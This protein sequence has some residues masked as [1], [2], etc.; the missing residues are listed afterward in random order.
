MIPIWTKH[1]EQKCIK[2]KLF[3]HSLLVNIPILLKIV[4]SSMWYFRSYIDNLNFKEEASVAVTIKLLIVY[5]ALLPI[6]TLINQYLNH[7]LNH[8]FLYN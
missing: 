7:I 5:I 3:D 6:L 8:K 4:L 2:L 1:F